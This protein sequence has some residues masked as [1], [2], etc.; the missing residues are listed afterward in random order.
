MMLCEDGQKEA[1]VMGDDFVHG[2][3]DGKAV[4][5]EGQGQEA[6]EPA[7]EAELATVPLPS[8]A[9]RV[10]NPLFYSGICGAGHSSHSPPTGAI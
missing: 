8:P 6:T 4:P 2:M 5:Y 3:M 10:G 9:L 7:T 1:E